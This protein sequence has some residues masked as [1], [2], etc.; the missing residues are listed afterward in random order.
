[1]RVGRLVL[2]PGGGQAVCLSVVF[3]FCISKEQMPTS[4]TSEGWWKMM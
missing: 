3:A 4:P 1:M 2:C